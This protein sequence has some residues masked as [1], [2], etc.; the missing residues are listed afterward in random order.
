MEKLTEKYA[1]AHSSPEI[2][3]LS[4]VFRHTQL[5]TPF[6]RMVS[7]HMQ[8]LLLQ[9]IAR[10]LRPDKVLEI[11]TFTGYSAIC[12]AQGLTAAG[13]IDT[14]EVNPEM[15][16]VILG[17][18]QEAGLSDR[19]NL[20][21]GDALEIIPALE[22]TYDLVFIDADKEQYLDY[23][24]LVFDKVRPGGIILVDNVLWGGKVLSSV[25]PSDKEATGVVQFNAF[26]KQDQ[27]VERLFLP[28]R[29]GLMVLWKK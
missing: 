24:H 12:F 8:G 11:G 20:M 7:G 10:M 19:I 15:E 2:P 9:M 26:I 28:L 14:I 13:I 18:F 4:K 6:P 1:E 16:E 27:R 5:T 25:L 17:N 22:S 29:D 3:V 21:I 23:Y